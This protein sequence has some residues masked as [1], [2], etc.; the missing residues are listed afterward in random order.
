MTRNLQQMKMDR[1]DNARKQK[2]EGSMCA[3][4]LCTGNPYETA[5][6]GWGTGRY[7]GNKLCK[8]CYRDVVD[9]LALA[10]HEGTDPPW[11]HDNE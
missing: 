10:V 2:K 9:N 3:M 6:K 5:P 8:D 7:G 1:A 4:P 11:E